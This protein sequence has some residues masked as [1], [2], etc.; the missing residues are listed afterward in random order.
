MFKSSITI[1]RISGI[2]IRIHVS[3]LLI[4]AF[5]TYAIGQ[6]IQSIANLAGV[7]VGDL[8]V[9]PY[10]LGLILTI[11]LFVSVTFHE[12]AHSFV[13]RRQGMTIRSIT[14]MLLGGVAQMEEDIDESGEMMMALAGPLFS[15]VFGIAL[16]L[17]LRVLVPFIGPDTRLV[18]YYLGVI[19]IFLAV[20]NM[21]PAF[22][23]DGGRILRS[24]IARRVPYL[25]ATRIATNIGKGFAVLFAIFGFL[26]GNLL[27]I[28]IAFFIYVGASQEYQL[29]VIRD[30]FSGFEVAD[31]M[32]DEVSTVRADDSV[33]TLLRRMM[34]ER[35][36]GY[37][38]VNDSGDVV[39]C[40]TLGDVRAMPQE[41]AGEKRIRD[42][43]SSE[44][45]TVQPHDDLYQAF[46]KL[47]SADIGRLMVLDADGGLRGI[48]TRSDIMKVYRI[49]ALQEEQS[50]FEG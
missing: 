28:L 25:K 9:N 47:S 19:N 17:S 27:L 14:L 24:L 49:K 3:F 40:V 37:P 21:L 35:H 50:R 5:L 23:S 4:L 18:I 45:I 31:V 43:M 41:L 38:V 26:T 36:S 1:L 2:P 34:D 6:N 32:S 42:I 29:N 12:L 46:K 11:L 48:L 39:G 33:S 15:F 44:L 30:V 16:L 13:A 10:G 8:T 22:P 7:N 20:F